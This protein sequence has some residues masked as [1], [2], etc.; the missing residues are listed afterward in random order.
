MAEPMNSDLAQRTRFFEL[1]KMKKPEF[2]R[3]ESAKLRKFLKGD[4]F[5]ITVKDP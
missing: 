1:N 4:Q 2:A 5:E 3:R